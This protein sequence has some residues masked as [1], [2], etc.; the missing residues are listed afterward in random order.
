KVQA[1]VKTSYIKSTLLSWALASKRKEIDN[2]I[3]R[4]DSIWDRLIFHKI[5]DK[6]GGRVKL[7]LSG[8][9]PLSAD[10]MSFLRCALG[11]IVLE[12]YGQTEAIPISLTL[13][14]DSTLGHVGPPLPG[15]HI[16]LVDVPEMNFYAKDGIGE[17]VT[18]SQYTMSEYYK[19]PEKTA[20][21][22][23]SDGWL[24]TE[25]IG[26]W[27]ENGTLKIVDRKKNVF[28]LSQGEYVATEKIENVY[29]ASSL[30]GQIF[31]DGDST[32]PC[33]MA[34]VVPDDVYL[35]SWGPSNDFPSTVEE[36]C[37]A[38]G[39]KQLVLND[40]IAEGKKAGIMAFEQVK[41]IF[42]EANFFTVENGLLTPTMKNKRIAL[43]KKYLDQIQQLYK[44]NGL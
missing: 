22:L 37:K 11:C 38:Q 10:V 21:A 18:K 30:V 40:M 6:L 36:F 33:L 3:I 12:G 31:V 2:H 29:R 39:A 32:K 5:Q 9:A 23:D 26:T 17:I 24:H 19:Q 27:Q 1:D 20:G 41:D 15:V 28:K 34:I 16:K 14:G 4:R 7:V 8:A 35:A 13:P 44:A 25:D 42:L 43:R